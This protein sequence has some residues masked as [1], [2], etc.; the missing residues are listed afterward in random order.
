MYGPVPE[1][2]NSRDQ[3]ASIRA[4]YCIRNIS[5]AAEAAGELYKGGARWLRGKI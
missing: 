3:P 1:G 4:R 5:Y 2:R